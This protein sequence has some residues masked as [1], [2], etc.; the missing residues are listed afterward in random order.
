MQPSSSRRLARRHGPL[1]AAVAPFLERA[2]HERSAE[3]DDA[4]FVLGR[5]LDFRGSVELAALIGKRPS[6]ARPDGPGPEALALLRR[7]VEDDL[8]TIRSQLERGVVR[9]SVRADGSAPAS[10]AAVAG[11]LTSRF[12]IGTRERR[13][14]SLAEAVWG[15]IVEEAQ[16]DLEQARRSLRALR[17]DLGPELAG[18]GG[19]AAQLCELDAVLSEGIEPAVSGRLARALSAAKVELSRRLAPHVAELPERSGSED[20][21]PWLEP[22]GPIHE[23]I[24]LLCRIQRAALAL[25]ERRLLALLDEAVPAASPDTTAAA[26]EVVA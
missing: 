17:R 4:A 8:A 11:A 18:L 24:E 22:G 20:V 1:G 15:P 16:R 25:E 7:H 23:G 12:E 3:E 9:L 13:S 21:A 14:G 26:P 10:L 6:A 5:L 2:P 19:K